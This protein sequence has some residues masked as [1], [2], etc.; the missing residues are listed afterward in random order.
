M[1]GRT[2]LTTVASSAAIPEP[3]TLT[4]STHRRGAEEYER[5][6][7]SAAVMARA[8]SGV[9]GTDGPQRRSR[10]SP[11]AELPQC[12]VHAQA[13]HIG[14][15]QLADPGVVVEPHPLAGR[16]LDG[17]IGQVVDR[18]SGTGPGGAPG[19]RSPWCGLVRGGLVRWARSPGAAIA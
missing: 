8:G 1:V 6:G 9:G 19:P 2:M 18:V 12:V 16:A 10:R 13:E 5:S 4:P 17:D 3:S 15:G 11:V 7:A 14:D